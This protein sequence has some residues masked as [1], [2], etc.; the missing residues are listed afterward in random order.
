MEI[1]VI[2]VL[3][4]LGSRKDL[5]LEIESLHK[6]KSYVENLELDY[7]YTK[8]KIRIFKDILPY[9]PE[10]YIG[11][12]G[13][14]IIATEKILRILETVEY[15]G[16]DK[17]VPIESLVLDPV[18]RSY[19]IVKTLQEEIENSNIEKLGFVLDIMVNK[20]QYKTLAST[21]LEFLSNKEALKD[22]KNIV[23]L[24]KPFIGQEDIGN[25]DFAKLIGVLD[26][27]EPSKKTKEQPIDN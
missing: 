20:E 25:S 11:T 14:S 5:S 9:L 1:L 19:K 7:T 8:E 2:I 15:I 13:R 18:E 24:I 10:D 12:G 17:K 23:K 21:A 3:L 26:I 4:A 6:V 16:V 27:F 22:P